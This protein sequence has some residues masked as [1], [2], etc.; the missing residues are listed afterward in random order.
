MGEAWLDGR[1]SSTLRDALPLPCGERVG[2]RG[3][4]CEGSRN[5][6]KRALN[7]GQC[8]IVPETQHAVTLGFQINPLPRRGEQAG[9][10]RIDDYLFGL[11]AQ[12]VRARSEE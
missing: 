6:L 11:V 2:V 5:R 3:R 1:H 10:S 4:A 12:I 7:L 8:L 9:A